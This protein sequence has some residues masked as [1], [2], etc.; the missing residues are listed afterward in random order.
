MRQGTNK[1]RSKDTKNK[2]EEAAERSAREGVGPEDTGSSPSAS[3]EFS[4]FVE[5]QKIT[6]E[7]LWILGQPVL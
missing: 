4:V 6:H 3:C 2:E 5:W 1:Q 7:L